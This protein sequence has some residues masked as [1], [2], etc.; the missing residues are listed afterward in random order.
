MWSHVLHSIKRALLGQED[1]VPLHVHTIAL[2]SYTLLGEEVYRYFLQKWLCRYYN[3]NCLWII[4]SEACLIKPYP[5]NEATPKIRK[6]WLVSR[7]AGLEGV[8]CRC[9]H[10]RSATYTHARTY[11]HTYL[12]ACSFQCNASLPQPVGGIRK[13]LVTIASLSSS[14]SSA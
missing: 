8:H 11:I 13:F 12:H 9:T 3:I 5:W 10:K 1:Y 2:T 14:S 4:Y 7:V 6:L